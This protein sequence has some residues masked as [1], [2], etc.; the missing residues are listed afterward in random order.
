LTSLCFPTLSPASHRGRFISSA[1]ALLAG[2]VLSL[3]PCV[4]ARAQEPT[5]TPPS[6]DLAV[7]KSGDESARVGATITYNIVV[8]NGGP[9]TAVNVVLTDNIPA[10][11]TFVLADSPYPN[12]ADPMPPPAGAVSFD[13]TTLTVTFDSIPAFES[14]SARLI[15]RVNADAAR[16]TVISNT[17]TGTADSSD[18]FTEDNSATWLTAVTGP[19]SGDILISE[20]RLRGPAGAT[21]EY[22]EIYNNADTPH[23]VQS[24]D[25]SQ[26]YAVAAS[27]GVV[28]CIVP[29]GTLIPRRGHFLCVNSVGY[30]LGDYPAGEGENSTAAGD[31]TYETDIADN[32]GIAI[33]RTSNTENFNLAHRLDA[34]GSTGVTNALYREGAG[35]AP[36]SA[37]GLDYALYRDLCGKGGSVTAGGPCPT[38]GL[39]KDTDDNAADFLYVEPIGNPSGTQPRRLGAPGPENVSSP[40]Q[41]NASFGVT[42]LDPCVGS[43]APPNRVRDFTED[44]ANN[45]TFGTLDIRRTVT[46][47]TGQN[48]TRLRW[49]IVDISTFPAPSGTADLRA[50]TS[51]PISVTVDR[52]PCGSGTSNVT[53]Q[54]TTL[55]TPPTQ[56]NGGGFNSS[57]SSG[58]VTLDTPLADGESIDVRFLLGIQQTGSFKF[59][60]NVE[61][62][63]REPVG[64]PGGEPGGGPER[65][66]AA[67]PVGPSV[68]ARKGV[69]AMPSSPETG[70]G[71][72][73]SAP[74]ARAVK[75]V[76]APP[77]KAVKGGHKHNNF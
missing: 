1:F 28:R 52:A 49:R 13:G 23:L 32:A 51:P 2:L 27:D 67:A 14:R 12:P 41:S 11:T 54:G 65:P 37:L 35:Y 20:F 45:A 72:G 33:F 56:A 34:A 16:G 60:I 48:V 26:G 46:N 3:I 43:A 42:L 40:V 57:L 21:D 68:R 61:A 6:A 59:F 9:D 47:G 70:A 30:S 64:G 69:T 62:L 22:I 8:S 71:T 17:V 18:P 25:D 50:R 4:E 58:T 7:T 66:S 29:N 44:M 55:E 10:G 74:P 77:V 76:S 19:F 24:T 38:S 63:T 5:P 39:P 36:L 73:A 53:V 75:G 15:V 31:L